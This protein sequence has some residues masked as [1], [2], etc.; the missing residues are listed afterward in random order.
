MINKAQKDQIDKALL[1]LGFSK[2]E[3]TVYLATVQRDDS[4]VVTIAKDSSLSRG[5]VYDIVEKLKEKGYLAETKKGKKR[6]IIIEN[7]TSRFYSLLDERH[8]RLE[9]TK[10]T[11]DDVLPLIKSINAS[12]DFK[13]QI[14]L[15]TGKKGFNRAWDDI[16]SCSEKKF[17]SIARI[18]TFVEFGGE[19]FIQKTQERKKK[20]GFSSRAINETSPW[21]KKMVSV[22]KKYNRQTILAPK[23]FSFPT[24]E[25]IYGDK[26]AMF[27]TKEEN[28]VLVIESK[29][30]A[31]THKIYFEMIWQ[32]LG[33]K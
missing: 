19:D 4:S 2:K 1:Q 16:F 18:E 21:A 33:G 22:D 10:K 13:P 32:F 27:S 6:R 26:I 31:Q 3:A 24:T 9:K 11:V 28:I 30:F 17:L 5:T 20:L 29:D 14:R 25:I 12:E 8:E 15:Y 7:P 23:E